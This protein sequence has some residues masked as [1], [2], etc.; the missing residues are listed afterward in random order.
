M[1]ASSKSSTGSAADTAAVALDAAQALFLRHGYAGVNLERIAERAGVARQ[2]LYNRFGSKEALFRAM[3]ARHW[4]GLSAPTVPALRGDAPGKPPSA[5]ASLRE[6]ASA[7]IDFIDA[8]D[9]IDFIRL[10]IAESRQSPW[11][12]E[13]FYRIGKAPLF[14]HLVDRLDDLVADSLLACPSTEL[15]AHQ[16]FGLI[17]EVT[18]WPRVMAIGAAAEGLPDA[19]T[20]VDEAILMFM[21]RYRPTT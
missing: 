18:L 11:I 8:T 20:V 12:A 10:V 17:Q 19:Q 6:F 13:E 1:A 7:I 21:A 15:A 4:A 14:R 2:T 9:Q 5:E 3:L 16:F